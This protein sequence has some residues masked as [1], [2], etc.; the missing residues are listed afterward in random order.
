MHANANTNKN[1][2]KK[3]DFNKQNK[4]YYKSIIIKCITTAKN[5][6]CNKNKIQQNILSILKTKNVM[7]FTAPTKYC[8]KYMNYTDT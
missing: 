3:S 8:K 6:K 2:L 7:L 4:I 5:I 1:D